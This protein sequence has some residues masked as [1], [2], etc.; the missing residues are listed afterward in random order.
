[1]TAYRNF[2]SRTRS[3]RAVLAALVL[4]SAAFADESESVFKVAQRFFSDSLY[5]LALEQYRK[6]LGLERPP[7]RDPMVYYRSAVCLH[8]MGDTREA[9]RA[10]EDFIRKYPGDERMM[11][12]M[13]AAGRARKELEDYKQASDWFHLVWSRFVGSAKASRAL[14]EAAECARL[15]TNPQ[16]AMELYD[17]YVR[18]FPRKEQAAAASLSLAKLQMEA[19]DYPAAQRTLEKADKMGGRDDVSATRTLYLKARLAQEMNETEAAEEAYRAMM[20]S[21]VEQFPEA[22]RAYRH[23]VG[24]LES[25]KRFEESLPVYAALANHLSRKGQAPNENLLFSWGEAARKAKQY[26][27]AAGLYRRILQQ[28]PSSPKTAQVEFRLAECRAGMDD[29][30]GAVESLQ[31]IAVNDSSGEYAHKALLRMGD[32]YFSKDLWPSAI[33]AY[34][35]YLHLPQAPNKDRVIFRIGRIYQEKFKRFGAASREYQTLLSR[36]PGSPYYHDALY[37]IAQC[38][39]QTGDFSSAMREYEYLLESGAEQKLVEKA[40]DRLDYLTRFKRKSP[41][42]AVASLTQ[43]LRDSYKDIPRSARLMRIAQ[44]YDRHLKQFEEALEI[45]DEVATL[46]PAPPES[47]AVRAAMRKAAVHE[48]LAR[49]ASYEGNPKLASHHDGKA[50]EVYESILSR[51]S[52]S[53]FNAEAAFRRMMLSSPEIGQLREFLSSYPDSPYQ[54]EVLMEIARRYRREAKEEGS[55]GTGKAVEALAH[56]VSRFPATEQAEQ[57]YALLARSLVALGE[58]DSAQSVIATFLK[59]YEHSEYAPEVLYTRGI[60]ARKRGNYGKALDVFND[61]FHRY[62]FSPFAS[63]S[64]YELAAAQLET[65]RVFEALGNFRAY[66][67]DYPAGRYAQDAR[68]GIARCLVK[69][70]AVEEASRI[71][72]GLLESDVSERVKAGAYAEMGHIA[73]SNGD[74]PAAIDYYKKGLAARQLASRGEVLLALG[75]LYYEKKIYGDAAKAYR[76]A[77]KHMRTEEDSSRALLGAVCSLIMDGDARK[78]GS[79]R[80]LFDKRFPD[81][82]NGRARIVFTEGLHHLAGKRYEKAADR[83]NDLVSKYGQ[84]AWADNALYHRA[85]SY[86]Y[87]NDKEKSFKLFRETAEKYPRSEFVPAARFK[88]GMILHGNEEYMRAAHEFQA[89]VEDK[90]ADSETRYR[91]THNAALDFQKVAAWVDAA[92]MYERLLEDFPDRTSESQAHLKIGFCLVQGSQFEEALKHFRKADVN[93]N[94]EDRPEIL[95][96][97]ATCFS[98]LGRHEKAI[99]E[100]LKVP[101]LYSGVGKWGVTAELEAARLYERMGEFKKARSLYGKVVRSDGE[102][103][104]FGKQASER[105]K[106]LEKL[107]AEG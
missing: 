66:A 10:F 45:Y 16:R 34:R 99:A 59:R 20:Q 80:K 29:L 101:Y 97:I 24:F 106:R 96:W 39:E 46:E 90:R 48:K 32:L 103:G 71:L 44:I 19:G 5:N 38:H 81:D 49:Q 18:R 95:Y 102:H 105:L 28:F 41:E 98:K 21:N 11:D 74:L 42:E 104:Q 30:A 54:A 82:R 51:Y 67:E 31:R 23:Y 8:R 37:A 77:L 61:V 52:S 14:F 94:E 22:D 50:R 2:L 68:Y 76:T 100:Y 72:S 25:R 57:A 6:Y 27:Q 85:L 35:K 87:N 53:P 65:G 12:A 9:A 93:A 86:Y 40:R 55:K 73:R 62:P 15:D 92:R 69:T 4:S 33:V 58:L 78:S 84:T 79:Y 7:E 70:G 43:L 83:F 17:L 64:R 75:E 13:Y 60:I 1:M 63:L 36:H 56:L 88:V 91:A 26:E 107:T 3:A 47:T 89:V